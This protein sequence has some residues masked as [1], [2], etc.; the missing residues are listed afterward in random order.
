[1]GNSFRAIETLEENLLLVI[2]LV[3]DDVVTSHIHQNAVLF[4]QEKSIL[5]LRVDS[6]KVSILQLQIS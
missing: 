1:M 4:N 6:K 2:D 3:E 5:H